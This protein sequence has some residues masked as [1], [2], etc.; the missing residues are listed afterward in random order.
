MNAGKYGRSSAALKELLALDPL[1][2]EARRLFATLHLRLGSLMTAR[3]AFESLANEA[4]QRQDYWLAESLLKEYLAAGARCVPFLEMLAHVYEEKGD[5]MAA[6]EEYGKAIEILTEDVDPDHPNL[7]AEL[8]A[9]IRELAPASPEALRLSGL[10]DAATG[11]I[12]HP[13]TTDVPSENASSLASQPVEADRP[14]GEPSEQPMPWESVEDSTTQSAHAASQ[15]EIA[16]DDE[17]PASEVQHALSADDPVV[18]ELG[19]QRQTIAEDHE[20]STGTP[21]LTTEFP[22]ISIDQTFPPVGSSDFMESRAEEAGV[23]QPLSEAGSGPVSAAKPS[24]VVSEFESELQLGNEPSGA[25]A[26]ISSPMPWEQV[27]ET[28]IQISQ[29]EPQPALATPE[30]TDMLTELPKDEEPG[31]SVPAESR[32]GAL[33]WE[34]IL[35]H[36]GLSSRKPAPP[37]TPQTELVQHHDMPLQS[38]APMLDEQVA[39]P[40]YEAPVGRDAIAPVADEPPTPLTTIP[41]LET[42]AR[43]ADTSG[44]SASSAP[45]PWDQVEETSVPIPQSE[46][47]PLE[48]YGVGPEEAV[49]SDP[50]SPET[51]SPSENASPYASTASEIEKSPAQPVQAEPFVETNRIHAESEFH[52]IV[53]EGQSSKRLLSPEALPAGSQPVASVGSGDAGGAVPDQQDTVASLVPEALLFSTPE[54]QPV[55][56]LRTTPPSVQTVSPESTPQPPASAYEDIV[57]ATGEAIIAETEITARLPVMEPAASPLDLVAPR[58]G[59]T[60]EPESAVPEVSFTLPQ[61]VVE[62]GESSVFSNPVSAH[63]GSHEEQS[64]ETNEESVTLRLHQPHE[65]PVREEILVKDAPWLQIPEAEQESD[66]VM[67]GQSTSVSAPIREPGVMSG[68]PNAATMTSA[69]DVL[70]ERSAKQARLSTQDI[71]GTLKRTPR[72]TVPFARARMRLVFLVRN[73]V[74]TTRSIIVTVLSLVSLGMTAAIVAVGGTGLLWVAMEERPNNAF[75]SLTTTPQR[76]LSDPRKNGYLLLLGI[77][78]APSYDP[79]QAG[80]ERKSQEADRDALGMCLTE[81]DGQSTAGSASAQVLNGWQR[82]ADPAAQFK[83]QVSGIKNW[84]AQSDVAL[85]RYRQWLKMPFEDWGHGQPIVPN[86]RHIVAVHRLYLAEGFAQ[87]LDS[88]V[89]RLEA[90]MT[91]WRATLAQ[92]RSLPVKMMAADAVND[93]AA[94]ASGLLTRADLDLKHLSRLFKLM[95]PLDQVEQSVRWPMQSQFVLATKTLDGDLKRDSAD[96]RPWYVTVAAAMPLP[97]QHRFNAYADYYEAANRTSAEVH[98]P[99]MPKLSTYVKTPATGLLDYLLNPIEHVIGV[100][101]LPRWEDYSG[102]IVETD[103]RLRLVSLQAWVRKGSLDGDLVTR[104]AKAGQQFYDPFTGL[105][106]LINSKMGVMYS[107]G[108]DGKDQDGDPKFDVTVSI[109]PFPTAASTDSKRTVPA[110]KK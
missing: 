22:W 97:K 98:P 83:S 70:F 91:A 68:A 14:W 78:A 92:A 106:M 27:E 100:K 46:P 15:E 4:L 84:L 96:E 29:P 35:G 104:I 37:P 3:P 69:V 108:R 95:R 44:S 74:S 62:R 16:R 52:L 51:S 109:P 2:T 12:L 32:L 89:D 36:L 64:S 99:S 49:L 65:V 28:A 86:C 107:V 39:S 43:S 50:Q 17:A 56:E 60:R 76:S 48:F 19:S 58:P 33:S 61:A 7:P 38:L 21:F 103:A 8:Y 79:L 34:E 30:T 18:A 59:P 11:K 75:H 5:P 6:V 105:P 110:K 90:D 47:E 57:P 82:A 77:D 81:N 85:G 1:N 88:G 26:P 93:D 80:Y 102:R 54:H 13:S 20:S 25:Q 72:R 40:A 53:A 71:T 24:A 73:C 94:V 45:M 31:F 41:P 10:F 66:T 42:E 87:D 63:P 101:S 23:E 67:P 9:K 55:E